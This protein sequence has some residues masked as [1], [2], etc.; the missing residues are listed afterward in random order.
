MSL[1]LRQIE[2][3]HAV[4]VTGSISGAAQLLYISQPAV[5]R[6]LSQT[7]YRIGFALFERIK[8]RL[9][10]TP[11]AK[12]LFREVQS[13]YNG[14]QRVNAIAQELADNRQGSLN[15]VSSTNG[16]QMFIPNAIAAFRQSHPGVK[17]NFMILSYAHLLERLLDHQADLGLITSPMEH[18]NL[19]VERLGTNRLVALFPRGHP[20]EA[21]EDVRLQDLQPHALITY[22]RS[23]PFGALTEQFYEAQGLALDPFTEVG[24][25]YSASALVQLGAGVAL[26][27]EFSVK[28]VT[29]GLAMRPLADSPVAQINLV[30]YGLEPVSQTARAFIEVLRERVRKV[31]SDALAPCR[32]AAAA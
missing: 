20:L 30:Y 29:D 10:A 12:K 23:T 4:M 26:V 16:G 2:I 1:N 18:P 15:I 9:H 5:S 13:V 25:P 24:S 7:E 11:E 14:I 6:L 22:D 19:T 32:I 21:L 27:D 17:I 31:G 8:G 3:F 28:S